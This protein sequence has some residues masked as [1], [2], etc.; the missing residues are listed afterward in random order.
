MDGTASLGIGA[1]PMEN[2]SGAPLW[3]FK[4][5]GLLNPMNSF[6]LI[7]CHCSDSMTSLLNHLMPVNLSDAELFDPLQPPAHLELH[8]TL[9]N[10]TRER[11]NE[12]ERES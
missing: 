4:F 10:N 1:S 12:R 7:H 9:T 6:N 2:N 5:V 3:R 8:G 11:E